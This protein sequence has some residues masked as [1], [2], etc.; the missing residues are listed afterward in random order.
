M[1]VSN[2]WIFGRHR[3]LKLEL[4]GEYLDGR[5]DTA[6][7]TRVSRQL[8]SC[9]SCRD[10]LDGLRSTVSLL[11]TLPELSVPHSFTLAAPP[12][13]KPVMAHQP[14]PLRAPGWAYAGAASVAGL[15][16]AIMVSAD[17]LG[18]FNPTSQTVITTISGE[19]SP[20]SL[21]SAAPEAASSIAMATPQ[22]EMA[23]AEPLVTDQTEVTSAPEA[24][25]M[26]A[27]TA[28]DNSQESA[29]I[30]PALAPPAAD[31]QPET[32]SLAAEALPGE[33]GSATGSAGPAGA[34][35]PSDATQLEDANVANTDLLMTT[36]NQSAESPDQ[37]LSTLKGKGQSI[38]EPPE[39]E[40]G[41]TAVLTP[42]QY[43]GTPIIWRVLEGIT[44]AL[45][46]GLLTLLIIKRL[47][48]RRS[49]N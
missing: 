28:T 1:I 33:D 15:A 24:D 48:S 44:T 43:Q 22:P 40:A 47:M 18:L 45:L 6:A 30:T 11:Q 42:A 25:S 36:K 46:L 49:S 32:M 21:P 5:L 17:T 38:E 31:A 14:L 10:E 12:I 39:N 19:R 3:H 9:E 13:S 16:L 20:E 35:G 29:E 34:A 41:S 23:S 26:P 7:Q 8:D 4:L 2:M 37:S 27:L